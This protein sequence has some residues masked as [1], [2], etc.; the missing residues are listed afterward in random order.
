MSQT[1]D[2][3]LLVVEGLSVITLIVNLIL[4]FVHWC[5][6]FR[7]RFWCLVLQFYVLSRL[8]PLSPVTLILHYMKYEKLGHRGLK[9]SSF[10]DS[11][12]TV[13]TSGFPESLLDDVPKIL[14]SGDRRGHRSCYCC[15]STLFLRDSHYD[16]W[17]FCLSIYFSKWVSMWTSRV[18][19]RSLLC[20]WLKVPFLSLDWVEM[21]LSL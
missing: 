19:S 4:T 15:R 3:D 8:L 14:V 7:N 21:E 11:E 5:S 16:V 17:S 2:F 13:E 12:W 10:L 1:V 6:N 18:L 20:K 9:R